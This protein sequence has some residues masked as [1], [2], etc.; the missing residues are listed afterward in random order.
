MNNIDERQSYLVAI[1][2]QI[3]H[4]QQRIA[5]L[6][7]RIEDMKSIGATVHPQLEL[8]AQMRITVKSLTV[9]RVDALRILQTGEERAR[10]RFK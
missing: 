4:L 10:P 3:D 6:I 7:T 8:L 2:F 9:A 1:D 5:A